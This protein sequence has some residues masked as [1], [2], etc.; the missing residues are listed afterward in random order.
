VFAER[1]MWLEQL[2]VAF[3]SREIDWQAIR[4]IILPGETYLWQRRQA[5]RIVWM[6]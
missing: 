1:V 4:N 6:R 3:L 5:N 2:S